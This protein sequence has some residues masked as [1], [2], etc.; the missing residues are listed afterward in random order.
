MRIRHDAALAAALLLSVPA[1]SFAQ[2]DPFVGGDYVEVTGISIDDGHYMDYASFIRDTAMKQN[3]F[4]VSKGWAIST[5]YM[6]NVHARKGEPDIYIVRRYKDVP[7][8][9]EGER[10]AAALRDFMKM[11][12]TQSGAASAERAKYRHVDGTM[13]LQV[14]KPR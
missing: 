6:A 4:M 8:T 3:A 1:A 9:A 14:M 10:R 7:D 12:D 11:D 5:E 2:N 13:L